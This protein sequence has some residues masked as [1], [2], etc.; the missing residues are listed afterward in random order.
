M[1]ASVQDNQFLTPAGREEFGVRVIRAALLTAVWWTCV[2]LWAAWWG[3]TFGAYQLRLPFSGHV[4]IYAYELV[5][6]AYVWVLGLALV[7]LLS[8]LTA[9]EVRCRRG[10][11]VALFVGAVTWLYHS[12]HSIVRE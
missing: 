4:L 7:L 5:Q 8:A 1:A 6:S 3:A 12:A 2:V 10:V 9:P 11:Y